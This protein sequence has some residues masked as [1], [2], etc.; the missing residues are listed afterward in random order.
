MVALN[1]QKHP[2]GTHIEPMR[3]K[4]AVYTDTYDEIERVYLSVLA[5][6]ELEFIINDRWLS[7]VKIDICRHPS[8]SA[9][10][11]D[12]TLY[13]KLRTLGM[14]VKTTEDFNKLPDGVPHIIFNDRD[15][16]EKAIVSWIELQNLEEAFP[17][18]YTCINGL[19]D[20]YYKSPLDKLVELMDKPDI[21]VP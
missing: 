12:D 9:E 15:S 13:Y 17:R 16:A 6:S 19:L 2:I 10:L 3:V 20:Q 11:N 1:H 21:K 14:R 7:H 8:K 18:M 4:E 5:Y